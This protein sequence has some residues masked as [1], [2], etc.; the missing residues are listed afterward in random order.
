MQQPKETVRL[1]GRTLIEQRE[2]NLHRFSK[3]TGPAILLASRA[4]AGSGVNLQAANV[5]ILCNAFWH[6]SQER[7]AIGQVWRHTQTKP[8]Y[9]YTLQAE[10][11]KVEEYKIA[12]RN[13][14]DAE[15]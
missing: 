10:D 5:V 7:Q 4:A 3:T 12:E 6:A 14:K 13:R 2:T 8:V 15:N 11:C 1:D 9:A